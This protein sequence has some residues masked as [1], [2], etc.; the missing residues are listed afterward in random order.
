MMMAETSHFVSDTLVGDWRYA[1]PMARHVSWKAGGIAKQT[2]TPASL[3]ALA[4][5]LP[6]LEL[7]EPIEF[8]GLG[9]NLLV[10]DGGFNGTVI[11]THR[12]L[13][14]LVLLDTIGPN[15]GEG[16][17][18]FAAAGV[19]SPHLA[20]FAAN[21]DLGGAEWLAGVPGTVG[22]ALAMNAG[23]YGGETW[24]H[25]L[26]CQTIDRAGTI[27]LRTPQDFSIGYRHVAPAAPRAMEWFTAAEFRFGRGNRDASRERIKELLA[28]RVA[29]QPLNQPNA[30]SV[31]RNPV[32]DHAARLIE[33]CGLKGLR[34]GGAEVSRKHANFIVNAGGASALDIETLINQV[35][36]DVRAKTGVALVREVRIIG[37]AA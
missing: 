30:G 19:P 3:K 31:F 20:K 1:E 23:C 10:R 8:V 33:S 18:V 16:G 37:D 4:G 24:N 26:R 13:A 9:S 22:G 36:A 32:G 11:F 6:T 14:G 34:I 28:Q 27:R 15:G 5:M 17:T 35:E 12:A 7:D 29:A 21:N 25:I 2:F